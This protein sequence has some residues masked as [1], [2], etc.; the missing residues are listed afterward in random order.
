MG[1]VVFTFSQSVFRANGKCKSVKGRNLWRLDYDIQ[2]DLFSD[3]GDLQ[4][5]SVVEGKKVDR[6]VIEFD[7]K[8]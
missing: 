7:Q 5:N 3:R 8:F 2:V 6:A 1:K 4:F